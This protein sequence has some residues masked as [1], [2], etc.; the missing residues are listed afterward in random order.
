MALFG[1]NI[2][3]RNVSRGTFHVEKLNHHRRNQTK[4]SMGYGRIFGSAFSICIGGFFCYTA[5]HYVP[6]FVDTAKVVSFSNLDTSA[7]RLNG[8][9]ERRSFLA[10]YF[11]IFKLKKA[12]LKA[13][14]TMQVQYALPKNAQLKLTITQCRSILIAE[15]FSCQAIGRRNVT[16]TTKTI[17]THEF[18]FD[19]TG[20][21]EFSE[22]VIQASNPAQPYEVIWRRS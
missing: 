3:R 18:S 19:Q 2:K 10:P 1:M 9:K 14:Q 8:R 17:G 13:G 7:A 20:F 15:V 6:A 11:D 22:T 21:Y 16:L 12:Y 4:P 5:L